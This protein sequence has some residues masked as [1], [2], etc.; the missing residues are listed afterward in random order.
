MF[1]WP[2]TIIWLVGVTVAMNFIDGLDGLA[3]GIAAIAAGTLAI[4]ASH[5]G[6]V[7][8]TV[9]A[10]AVLGSI[11]GFLPYNFNPAKVFMGDAGSMFLGFVV[12]SCS[13][14]EETKRHSPSMLLPALAL[15]IPIVDAAFTLVRRRVLQRRSIFSAERGHIHHRLLDLG[16]SHRRAVLVLYAV[17]ITGATGGLIALMDTWWSLFVG[18]VITIPLVVGFF[19]VVGAARVGETFAALRRNR[20]IEREQRR[21]RMVFEQMQLRFANARTFEAWWYEANS[22]AESF[23]FTSLTLTLHNRDGTPR[24]LKWH[25]PAVALASRESMSVKLPIRQRRQEGPLSIQIE[26]AADSS[27]E[28]AGSRIALFSRLMNEYSVA[29]LPFES[30][31]SSQKEG[32]RSRLQSICADQ[33]RE[34]ISESSA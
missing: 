3:A 16:F 20:T 34:L 6:Q 11:S 30:A 7:A 28:S 32:R 13:V 10:L 4:G 26:V 12:A 33:S 27:L 17:S 5:T 15:C 22:A 14:L 1:A 25:S 29:H 19:H 23:D 24:V 31:E 18:L 9:L 21:S 8:T 2:I